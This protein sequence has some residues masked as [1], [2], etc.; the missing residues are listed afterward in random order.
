MRVS[1]S[2]LAI[3]AGITMAQAAVVD[4]VL[5]PKHHIADL[6]DGAAVVHALDLAKAKVNP[7]DF[8]KL[9]HQVSIAARRG[10]DVGVHQGADA[11]AHH[12]GAHASAH[13]GAHVSV[14]GS[15]IRHVAGI[16]HTLSASLEHQAKKAD[17][18][19]KMEHKHAVA[20]TEKLLKQVKASLATAVI[21]IHYRT[22]DKQSGLISRDV[23]QAVDLNA[24]TSVISTSN[25]AGSEALVSRL[26]GIKVDTALQGDV[27]SV[28]SNLD[29]MKTIHD[30]AN[31]D[32]VLSSLVAIPEAVPLIRVVQALES[33][34]EFVSALT[35]IHSISA[36]IEAAPSGM[37]SISKVA[38]SGKLVA[39]AGQY[40]INT[41][42][43]VLSFSNAA[44]VLTSIQAV[45]GSVQLLNTLKSV[46]DVPAFVSGL[47]V[48]S[49]VPFTSAVKAISDISSLTSVLSVVH[50]VVPVHKR[51]VDPLQSVESAVSGVSSEMD[52]PKM[53]H[54]KRAVAF[55]D[56]MLTGEAGD[57]TFG[58][59]VT[60]SDGIWQRNT[61]AADISASL[62][63][64]DDAIDTLTTHVSVLMPKL[65]AVTDAVH[66]D[67]ITS[68]VKTEVAPL[69]SAVATVLDRVVKVQA[70]K[71]T[72]KVKKIT[73]IATKTIQSLQ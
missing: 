36:L 41:V 5:P 71:L 63:L 2:L 27:V 73:S 59:A 43:R 67:S 6:K 15:E 18:L 72:N 40:G 10:L 42:A 33:P 65:V 50:N 8:K 26:S 23:L 39:Y 17:K 13:Q 45:P 9:E 37:D 61:D 52:L 56:A 28:L 58:S 64:L 29:M 11:G 1:S 12:K 3:L 49:V 4:S 68:D 19:L 35:D 22:E 7:V 31:V 38:G 20:K 21:D 62:P 16:V 34:A 32:T 14:D 30:V 69:V 53:L 54:L 55:T 51:D 48:L 66:V 47:N 24:V 70:P 57:G 46:A 25:V 44:G 60:G